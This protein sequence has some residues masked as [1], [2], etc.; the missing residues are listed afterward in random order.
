MQKRLTLELI[1]ISKDFEITMKVSATQHHNNR[2]MRDAFSFFLTHVTFVRD[3]FLLR[4]R[5]E[6][7]K[8]NISRKKIAKRRNE[9]EWGIP[10]KS[11]KERDFSNKSL[12]LTDNC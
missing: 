1:I 2:E 4:R 8:R 11:L 9:I 5:C 7:K 12:K 6:V 3:S 10:S